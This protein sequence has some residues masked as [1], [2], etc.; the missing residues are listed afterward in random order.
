MN[1]IQIFEPEQIQNL[2]YSFRGEQ[3]MLDR[4]LA[5]I[6]NVKTGRLN[7]AV[8]RNRDRFPPKFMFQ[9]TKGELKDWISQIE[10]SNQEKMGIRKMPYAFTE[11]GIQRAQSN[12][13]PTISIVGSSKP[14]KYENR[15]NGLKELP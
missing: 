1:D 12:K 14:Q 13:Q 15:F 6:Y 7:E 2:I 8:K 4:D 10:V 11:Q 9:L 5:A 3:V